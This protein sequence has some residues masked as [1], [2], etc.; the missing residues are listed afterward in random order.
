M[1]DLRFGKVKKVLILKAEDTEDTA[2]LRQAHVASRGEERKATSMCR[3]PQAVTLR[4]PEVDKEMAILSKFLEE[5]RGPLVTGLSQHGWSDGRTQEI[6]GQAGIG[7][8][9]ITTTTIAAIFL[10]TCSMPG[11]VP[12]TASLNVQNDN[13]KLLLIHFYK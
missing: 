6:N 5:G 8:Q 12:Y 4:C 1:A 3:Y 7:I 2:Q 9:E 10:S 11:T 13:A